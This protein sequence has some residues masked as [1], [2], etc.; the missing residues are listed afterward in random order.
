M[1]GLR[2]A[3]VV[4]NV[5]AFARQPQGPSL[6]QS[7]GHGR[8]ISTEQRASQRLAR[9]AAATEFLLSQG[10]KGRTI[11]SGS[12][13]LYAMVGFGV[14][15]AVGV[16]GMFDGS[17]PPARAFESS[18]LGPMYRTY[19]EG[20]I[21]P[22]RNRLLPDWPMPNVP[23]DLPCP[24][25]LV[26]DLED[27]LVRSEWSRKY[28]WRHAKRPGVDEFLATLSQYYEI[29]LMSPGNIGVVEPV[30]LSLDTQ[31]CI[32]HRLFREAHDYVDGV[33]MKNLEYMNRPRGRIVVVDNDPGCVVQKEN[34]ISVKR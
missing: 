3:K 21:K 14:F 18:G 17:S 10:A 9:R 29:V 24:H 2:T 30:I 6:R 19:F 5:C 1:I 4:R 27:T 22:N 8:L 32:M 33:H 25:T 12:R 23:P 7:L 31:N 20:F 26:L 11:E 13:N 28:G 16:W 15:T 34:V